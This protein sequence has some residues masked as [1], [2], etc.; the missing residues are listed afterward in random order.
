MTPP[1]TPGVSDGHYVY[2]LRCADDSYYTGYT[3]D[4][5]RRVAEHNAGDGAKYTRGRTPVECVYLEAHDSTSDAM[6]RE[7][8]IKQYSRAEKE[9]LVADAD[10]TLPA[11]ESSS[12]AG[13]ESTG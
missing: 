6:S 13:D 12:A 2:I 3:T 4:P 7:Y 11:S 5:A 1:P 9:A 10:P 8:E